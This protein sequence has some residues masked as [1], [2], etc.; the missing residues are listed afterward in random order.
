MRALRALALAFLGAACAK[1]APV[2]VSRTAV[3]PDVVDLH[4]DLGDAVHRRG[5]DLASPEL[6]ANADR[7][8]RGHVTELVSPLFV[9]D[10]QD[11][12][13]A[14]VLA[15]YS[16]I[17]RDLRAAL[18]ASAW[19][20]TVILAFEGADGFADDPSALAGFA[21]RGACLVGLVHR[22]SNALGGASQE[23]ASAER[24]RGLSDR[25]RAVARAALDS[26]MLLD[27]AHASDATF[28][29]LAALAES[30]HRPIVDS[31]T[32]TRSL[33]DIERN[34]DD[35][36]ILRIARSGGVVGIDVHGGHV[37]RT[38]GEPPTLDDVAAHI[39]HAL[40]IA[41]IDHVAIGS[42]LAGAIDA[43][44][45]S[46]GAAL[47]PAL[48]VTLT[49]R[50]ATAAAIDA[51]FHANAERVLAKCPRQPVAS[52]VATFSERRSGLLRPVRIE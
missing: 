3:P 7:L 8:A 35:A 14:Q 39:E 43:P 9:P 40:A 27:V 47:F 11:R 33:V 49:R 21:A 6:D 26:G 20:G 51:V 50:G 52:T 25:G 32:G 4:V 28:D 37:S 22:R 34:L 2:A 16:V 13:S 1:P 44:M 18:A 17:E 29:D 42:D 15:E 45:G 31:H 5:L 46:D 41:G 10:A 12:P 23:P 48:A 30:A 19:R 24:K 36:R 38:P